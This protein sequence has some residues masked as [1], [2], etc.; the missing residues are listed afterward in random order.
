MQLIL[1]QAELKD[2]GENYLQEAEP[3]IL[4]MQGNSLKWHYIR[5]NTI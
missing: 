2:F 5:P 4:E 3:K 1:H